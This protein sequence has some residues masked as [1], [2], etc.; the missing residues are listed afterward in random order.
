MDFDTCS[1]LG[2]RAHQFYVNV[3]PDRDSLRGKSSRSIKG[4][5]H[6]PGAGIITRLAYR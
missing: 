5:C 3:G 6:K 1:D 4:T 2:D